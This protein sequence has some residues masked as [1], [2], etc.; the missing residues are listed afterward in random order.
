MGVGGAVEY[1]GTKESVAIRVS[2]C[3]VL[4]YLLS[5]TGPLAITSANPSGEP[6]STHHNTV[7]ETLGNVTEG[8]R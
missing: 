5:I 6:D 4:S 3:T 1:V 2:D 7:I 8:I